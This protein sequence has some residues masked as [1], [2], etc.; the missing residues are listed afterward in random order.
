MTRESEFLKREWGVDDVRRVV[1]CPLHADMR[2]TEGLLAGIFRKV[3]KLGKIKSLNDLILQ[4]CKIQ[5]RFVQKKNGKGYEQY[6]LSGNECRKLRELHEEELRIQTI[7]SA[8][9]E[10]EQ[11]FKKSGS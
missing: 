7:V 9:F 2:L 4:H 1:M 3:H 11:S 6:G 8:L 5:P 10:K